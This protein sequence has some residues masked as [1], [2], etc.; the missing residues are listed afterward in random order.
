MAAGR[1]LQDVVDLKALCYNYYLYDST[2]LK[3]CLAL[4]LQP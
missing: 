2:D 3:K 4:C 1:D